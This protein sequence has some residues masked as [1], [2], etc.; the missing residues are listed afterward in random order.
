M[1]IVQL[2]EPLGCVYLIS[3]YYPRFEVQRRLTIQF[4]GSVFAGAVSGVGIP[5]SLD[6]TS[7][8][9]LTCLFQLLAYGIFKM[10]GVKGYRAW[11]WVFILEGIA[12]CIF[13]LVALFVIPDW[14]ETARF[15]KE[16]ERQVLL[17]R[18]NVDSAGVKMDR[19]DKK[20]MKRILLDKKILFGYET[21]QSP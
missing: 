3:M 1:W 20:A 16:D 18:L 10:D 21:W 11:R 15:L 6:Y 17:H 13:A 2:I 14:P 5:M 12:T 4:S 8:S 19:L 9:S 7:F